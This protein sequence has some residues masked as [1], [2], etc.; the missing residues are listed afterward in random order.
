MQR[1]TL[2]PHDPEW[3]EVFAREAAAIRTSGIQQE[4]LAA[5]H[6]IG[7]TAIPGIRAKPIIDILCAVTDLARLD[8]NRADMERLGYEVMGEFGIPGRRYYR[9]NAPSGMR[10]HQIHAFQIGD[11]QIARHLAFRDFLRAHPEFAAEYDALKERLAEQFPTDLS[12]YTDGKD[13]FIQEIDRR[14]GVWVLSGGVDYITLP[15]S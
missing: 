8:A 4:I 12:Q 13:A 9:K 5:I 3:A 11:P 14:A 10:T 1:I 2:I 6:H 7:S 15:D